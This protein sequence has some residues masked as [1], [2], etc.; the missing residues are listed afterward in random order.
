LPKKN[1]P[2]R[3][4]NNLLTSQVNKYMLNQSQRLQKLLSNLSKEFSI[5][6]LSKSPA[7][8]N[9][10]KLNWFNREYIKMM[11]L[12]E[13]VHKAQPFIQKTSGSSQAHLQTNTQY[14][15]LQYLAYLLDKNRVTVLSE[16][17]SESECVLNWRKPGVDDLKWKKISLEESLSNLKEISQIVLE[18]HKTLQDKQTQ[19]YDSVLTDDVDV[20]FEN[21]VKDHETLIKQWLQDNQKDVGSYLWPLRVCLSG[22]IKSPSPFELLAILPTKEV[23]SRIHSCLDA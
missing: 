8:F 20:N 21:L 14:T 5:D 1:F 7:R 17:G 11:S 23:E 3:D 4:L 9:L 6:K 19:L 13:F 22:K 16:V 10:E 12:A 18:S 15:P 2:F